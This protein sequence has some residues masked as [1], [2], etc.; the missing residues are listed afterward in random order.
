MF[1]KVI[2]NEQRHLKH[3]LEDDHNRKL[4]SLKKKLKYGEVVK[5]MFVPTVKD[6]NKE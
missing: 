5:D 6:R 2:Q 1:T 4:L 3:K